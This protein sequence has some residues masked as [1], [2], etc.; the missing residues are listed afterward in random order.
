MHQLRERGGS[1]IDLEELDTNLYR[2]PRQNFWIPLGGRGVFGGQILGQALH[3]ATRTVQGALPVTRTWKI[4]SLHGYFLQKGDPSMDVIYRVKETSERRSFKTRTV[5]GIQRGA[6][7]F[8]CQASFAKIPQED[9]ELDHEDPPMPDVPPPEDC[10]AANDVIEDLLTKD[11]LSDAIKDRLRDAQRIP[12]EMRLIGDV[13]DIL[14]PE[15]PKLPPRRRLWVRVAKI[16]ASSLDECCAAYF[17]D[18]MLLVTALM[19]HGINFPSP[20]LG[21]VASLDHCMFFHNDFHADDWILYDVHSPR[22]AH[23]RGLSI[24]HMYSRASQKLVVTTVQEGLLRLARPSPRRVGMHLLLRAN[25]F[26]HDNLLP[27]WASL[28]RTTK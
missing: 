18:H 28:T 4:H 9:D 7:I 22:L 14:D 27:W 17:S 15:P 12:V 13:P 21:I 2:A 23:G 11:I 6:T 19:P 5:E 26:Y 16:H 25:R 24:G 8:T 1:H 10:I 20:R 3:A